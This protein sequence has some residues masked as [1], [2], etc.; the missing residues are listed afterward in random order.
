[1]DRPLIEPKAEEGVEEALIIAKPFDF[2]L[3]EP[4][5]KSVKAEP[6]CASFCD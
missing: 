4:T 6:D 1:M 2:G 5:L 3:S